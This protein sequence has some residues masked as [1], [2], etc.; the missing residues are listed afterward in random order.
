MCNSRT[1]NRELSTRNY[2]NAFAKQTKKMLLV[3]QSVLL[4]L[5]ADVYSGF[6]VFY[7]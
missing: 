3:L 1:Y 6:M 5:W 7:K 4:I 2:I